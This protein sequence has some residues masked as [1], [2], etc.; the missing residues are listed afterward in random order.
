M[1]PSLA[2]RRFGVIYK[3]GPV[4][5]GDDT[6]VWPP[7]T[8]EFS[9]ILLSVNRNKSIA[10]D[11]KSEAGQDIIRRQSPEVG[12]V[13]RKFR[14][15]RRR[16]TVDRL[17]RRLGIRLRLPF[18]ETMGPPSFASKKQTPPSTWCGY[19]HVCHVPARDR[20]GSSLRGLHARQG[21]PDFPRSGPS[22]GQRRAGIGTTHVGQADR[23]IEAALAEVRRRGIARPI[24][25]V[26]AFSAPVFDQSGSVALAITGSDPKA[27]SM[28]IGT[29]LLR[30]SC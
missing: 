13:D 3:L 23:R 9:P 21:N 11:L 2:G 6:R 8:R 30:P 4:E 17:W 19:C 5:T 10:L 16:E 28:R 25:G 24:P 18:G 1:I 20:Y 22:R 26:N 12:C 29:V 14:N 7:V 15:R 27:P